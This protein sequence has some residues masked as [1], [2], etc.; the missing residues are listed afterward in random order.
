MKIAPWQYAVG[1]AAF[2]LAYRWSISSANAYELPSEGDVRPLIDAPPIPAE[3]KDEILDRLRANIVKV[4]YAESYVP[5]LE[6]PPR[7]SRS[8]PRITEY[9][10][11]VGLSPRSLWCAAFVAWCVKHGLNLPGAP[12]WATGSV[13]GNRLRVEKALGQRLLDPKYVAYATDADV[14]QK[15]K[16]GWVINFKGHTE[17]VARPNYSPTQFQ[18]VGGNTWSGYDNALLGVYRRNRDWADPD[19]VMFYDPA[20]MSL[21]YDS[22][23]VA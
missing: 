23:N 9:N 14:R 19:V 18:T 12:R 13:S 21:I 2:F 3:S 22:P 7:N 1:A 16:A 10:A 5:V 15:V 17:I 20:A 11:T 4:A 8:S 6:N